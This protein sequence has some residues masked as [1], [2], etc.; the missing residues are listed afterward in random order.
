MTTFDPILLDIN[1]VHEHPEIGEPIRLQHTFDLEPI[2]EICLRFVLHI[3]SAPRGT[4]VEMNRWQ[5]GATQAGQPFIT[6]VTDYVTLENNVLLLQVNQ[7]GEF[8]GIW[9]ERVPCEEMP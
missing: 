6:E 8:G 4:I 3:D 7:P 2:R 9:L 5:V 1:G